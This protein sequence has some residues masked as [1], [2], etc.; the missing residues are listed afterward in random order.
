MKKSPLSILSSATREWFG[1]VS[2]LIVTLLVCLPQSVR[3]Q[4]QQVQAQQWSQTGSLST[5]R[6]GHTATLPAN[7]KVLVAGG[8]ANTGFLNTAEL[9]DSPSDNQC[10]RQRKGAL[11]PG[12]ELRRRSEALSQR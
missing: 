10:I 4:A 11:R 2:L 12:L 6:F 9:Y 3:V 7:G 8:G 1:F 5:A